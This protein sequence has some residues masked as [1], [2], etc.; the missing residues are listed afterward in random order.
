[1]KAVTRVN[2]DTAG[3]LK[4]GEPV[5]VGVRDQWIDGEI[6]SIGLEPS[7]DS[8]GAGYAVEVLFTPQE[9]IQ[10]RAGESAVVR[11]NE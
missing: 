3:S 2:L 8:E 9:Q 6:V 7:T 11:I 4:I 10:Y 1:M 5:K